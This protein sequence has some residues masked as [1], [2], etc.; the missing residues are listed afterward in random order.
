M[1]NGM[2]RLI[3]DDFRNLTTLLGRAEFGSISASP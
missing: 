1:L 3:W 2:L